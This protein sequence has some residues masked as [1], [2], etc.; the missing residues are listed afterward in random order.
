VSEVDV[1]QLPPTQYLILEVLAARYRCG[2]TLWTFESRFRWHLLALESGGLIHLMH[3]VEARTVR[4]GLT[5]AGKAASLSLSYN[6]PAPTLATAISTLPR[7]DE[8][9]L[10][11]MR[12]HQL[13][14]GAGIGTVI[15][16]VRA[17]LLRL[18]GERN[19]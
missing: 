1:D 17:D 19:A 5:E 7:T 6:L 3:G 12:E 10:A 8:Q 18:A 16:A 13:G 15:S 4:A 2:E 11:W 14:H 9:Y